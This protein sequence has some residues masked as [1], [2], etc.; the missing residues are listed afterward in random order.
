MPGV[1][2]EPEAATAPPHEEL[3]VLAYCEDQLMTLEPPEETDDGDAVTLTT[4]Y[5]IGVIVIEFEPVPPG[6]VQL[7]LYVRV[8]GPTKATI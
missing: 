4:G 1:E 3:Q 5:E 2:Y 8:L 7:M 6:P